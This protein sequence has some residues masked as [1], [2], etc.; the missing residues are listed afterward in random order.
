MFLS[1]IS[2]FIL[3]DSPLNDI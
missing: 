2:P 3:R 1:L